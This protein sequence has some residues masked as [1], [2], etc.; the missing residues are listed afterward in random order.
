MEKTCFIR[1]VE[2]RGGVEVKFEGDWTKADIEKARTV[3]Y[4]DLAIHLRDRRRELDELKFKEK[5]VLE[6]E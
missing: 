6:N 4:R 3:M 5:E 1:F 2:G